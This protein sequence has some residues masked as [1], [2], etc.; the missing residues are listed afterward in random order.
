MNTIKYI[1][2]N[3]L[4]D[5][6]DELV[7]GLSHDGSFSISSA[8]LQIREMNSEDNNQVNNYFNGS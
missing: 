4:V 6:P 8:L 2:V 3:P 7:W 5:L 1:Y